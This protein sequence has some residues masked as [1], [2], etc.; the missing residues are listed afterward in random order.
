MSL[1]LRGSIFYCSRYGQHLQSLVGLRLWY[2]CDSTG[3]RQTTGG[4]REEDDTRSR[5]RICWSA[6][7]VL[8]SDISEG[9]HVKQ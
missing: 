6:N 5:R 3:G 2:L 4:V 7:H 1:G 8:S 9:R